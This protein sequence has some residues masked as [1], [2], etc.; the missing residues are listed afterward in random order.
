VTQPLR[1]DK[2]ADGHRTYLPWHRQRVFRS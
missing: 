1:V 2:L